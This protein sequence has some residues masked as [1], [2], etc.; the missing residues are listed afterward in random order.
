MFTRTVEPCPVTT[1]AAVC[2]HNL[3]I[4]LARG[5]IESREGAITPETQPLPVKLSRSRSGCSR[6]RSRTGPR[7]PAKPGTKASSSF[8][9]SA[10]SVALSTRERSQC[11]WT[12]R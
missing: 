7:S 4:A 2:V 10:A 5:H 3:A 11:W 6:L 12:G 9:V 8:I 1:P